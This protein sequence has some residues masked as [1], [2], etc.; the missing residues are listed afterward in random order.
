MAQLSSRFVI[1]VAILYLLAYLMREK[2]RENTKKIG[3]SSDQTPCT[4]ATLRAP[5]K[6]GAVAFPAIAVP[7][8][9][10]I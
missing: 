6:F 7:V 10:T 2:N 5:L 3:D 8:N 4:S 1:M 9:E